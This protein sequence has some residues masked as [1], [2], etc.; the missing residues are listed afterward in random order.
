MRGTDPRIAP[1]P[2]SLQR[3]RNRCARS[4]ESVFTMT[5]I[6]VHDDR[7]RCSPS[8][9]IRVHVRPEGAFTMDRNTQTKKR[10]SSTRAGEPFRASG[11]RGVD[12]RFCAATRTSG[13]AATF[14]IAVCCCRDQRRI[15]SCVASRRT[16]TPALNLERVSL[17]S[18]ANVARAI[19][20]SARISRAATKI[21]RHR[22]LSNRM[23][24]AT[25]KLSRPT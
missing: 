3:G 1:L 19:D 14:S 24:L 20:P 6:G 8:V 16:G 11:S 25:W 15:R 2:T 9:G 4:P 12:N 13:I 17:S 7:N 10:R 5:G 21:G 18:S 22:N 23:I